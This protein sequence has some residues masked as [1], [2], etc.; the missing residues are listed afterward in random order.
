MIELGARP[1]CDDTFDAGA[2]DLAATVGTG[3]ARGAADRAI[4]VAA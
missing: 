4:A 3:A 2:M 1:V